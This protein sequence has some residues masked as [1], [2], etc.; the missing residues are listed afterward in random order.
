MMQLL[1]NHGTVA[2]SATFTPQHVT[3]QRANQEPW[4]EAAPETLSNH[5]G[6]SAT[7]DGHALKAANS[8]PG[9]G[10]S[11]S[12][13][14]GS[15]D[16]SGGTSSSGSNGSSDGRSEAVHSKY[17]TSGPFRASTRSS[18]QHGTAQHGTAAGAAAGAA[19][20]KAVG[21][22]LVLEQAAGLACMLCHNADNHFVLVN[23][24][25]VPLL[26]GLL[27]QGKLFMDLLCRCFS[28]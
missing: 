16:I 15:N 9:S 20:G 13:S 6:D 24:G 3:A 7:T 23:Q 4:H 19:G 1:R 8:S 28:C 21:P 25:V 26:V 5:A 22:E 18:A 12:S 2:P 27:Q 11:S 10:D 14:S 17:R